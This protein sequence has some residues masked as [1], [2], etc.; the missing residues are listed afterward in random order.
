[1]NR[2]C[3]ACVDS[4]RVAGELREPM[5]LFV[6]DTGALVYSETQPENSVGVYY[7]KTK[8]EPYFMESFEDKPVEA[9]PEPETESE[10]EQ[11]A[12]LVEIVP[13]IPGF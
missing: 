7:I 11:K 1:M 4:S 5:A 13:T 8:G 9:L 10:A 12:K 6:L 2:A 3:P